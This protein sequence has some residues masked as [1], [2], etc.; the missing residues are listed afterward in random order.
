MVSIVELGYGF[1]LAGR[2]AG[3]DGNIV[4]LNGSG[5]LGRGGVG[6]GRLL[7]AAVIG[8]GALEP[9]YKVGVC[10]LVLYYV[11]EGSRWAVVVYPL[12]D[13]GQHPDAAVGDILAQVFVGGFGHGGKLLGLVHYGMDVY[14]SHYLS[15]VLGVFSVS[16][17]VAKTLFEV[18]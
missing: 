15:P 12:G 14:A 3:T 8:Y 18:A 9:A 1:I 17:E 6:I 7:V 13:V 16:Y 11:A 4:Q 5:H 2:E 10:C